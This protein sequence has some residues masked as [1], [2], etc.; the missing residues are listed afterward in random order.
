LFARAGP[1]SD[2]KVIAML[3]SY[4]VPV[5]VPSD[6]YVTGG[7]APAAER[8]AFKRLLAKEWVANN[9]IS[10]VVA[11]DGSATDSHMKSTGSTATERVT[12]LLERSI[13]K[14]KPVPGQP[15]VKPRAL[16]AH[17]P[18]AAPDALVLQLTTR[19]LS[20]TGAWEQVPTE[21]WIVLER[22][23]QVKLLGPERGSAGDSWD[24]DQEAAAKLLVHFYPSSP[25]WNIAH[26]RIDPCS[27]KATL[28]SVADGTARLR[29]EGDFCMKHHFLTLRDDDRFV[30]ASVLGFVDFDPKERK[31][32][33]V[34]LVTDRATYTGSEFVAALRSV[35]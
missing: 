19:S 8:A 34:R 4:F 13:Q 5:A 20:G 27:L 33:S 25:N 28:V 30:E 11:P 10:Y 16:A 9:S 3:N 23:D 32:Q 22:A 18:A 29:I 21:D 15:L 6:D 35:P 14:Y 1:L 26:N 12:Q 17:K 31:I 2:D 24:V 7:K